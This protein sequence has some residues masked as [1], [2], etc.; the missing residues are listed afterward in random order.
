MTVLQSL[1]TPFYECEMH[2]RVVSIPRPLDLK[3]GA[4]S[5]TPLRRASFQIAVLAR[6]A[7]R[8]AQLL[9]GLGRLPGVQPQQ[10]QPLSGEHCPSCSRPRVTDP[11]LLYFLC[12]GGFYYVLIWRC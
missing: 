7:E 8:A 4:L 10:F 5:T 9:G 11:H 12:T 3:S 6:V 2:R 1:S